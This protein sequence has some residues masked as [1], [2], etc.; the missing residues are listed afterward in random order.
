MLLAAL[1]AVGGLVS[2]A[3]PAAAVCLGPTIKLDR[4]VVAPKAEVAV[5]G[6]GFGTDCNDTGRPG[7][8]LGEPARDITLRFRQGERTVVLAT[9]DADDDYNFRKTVKIP[10]T[11][12][13]GP[14]AIGGTTDQ[15]FAEA[16]I[17][18]REVPIVVG[19]TAL[20]PR[21]CPALK[22]SS[23]LPKGVH[24]RLELSTT[25]IRAG[26]VG[27]SIDA[28]LTIRN[29]GRK[30]FVLV[31]QGQPIVAAVVKAGTRKVVGSYDGAIAGTGVI[32]NLSRGQRAEIPVVVGTARCDQRRGA[33]LP[34]GTYGVRVGIGPVPQYL[35]PEARL[36]ITK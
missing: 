21:N 22:R 18:F 28:T 1:A 29:R 33:A 23:V 26:E 9:V 2:L 7:P 8:S 13:P 16:P 5:V 31:N 12:M 27:Q 14:A 20:T 4:E 30:P 25:S 17:P 3:D 19:E 32:I 15:A 35:A 34:P 10:R 24:L 6:E 36:R 11:A